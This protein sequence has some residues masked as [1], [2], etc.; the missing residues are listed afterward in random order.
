VPVNPSVGD[1][2]LDGSEMDRVEPI[3]VTEN[4]RHR[5]GEVFEEPPKSDPV[6]MAGSSV[7]GVT[8]SA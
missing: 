7:A 6:A 5:F 1:D 4:A 8:R 2:F 3:E